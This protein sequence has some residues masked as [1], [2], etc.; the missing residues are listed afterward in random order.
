MRHV[1]KSIRIIFLKI[2]LKFSKI[3]QKI[4]IF[5]SQTFEK[6]FFSDHLLNFNV[7]RLLILK[8]CVLFFSKK[9]TL[10]NLYLIRKSEVYSDQK[11][12]HKQTLCLSIAPPLST[13]QPILLRWK[14][15]INIC[16]PFHHFLGPYD[17]WV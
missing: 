6:G 9:T 15:P 13:H 3:F 1:L 17:K 7:F 14:T 16:F 8:F 5:F 10:R 11:K 4:F 2:F 12:K